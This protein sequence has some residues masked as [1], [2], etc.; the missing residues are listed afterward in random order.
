MGWSDRVENEVSQ[1][2]YRINWLTAFVIRSL[3]GKRVKVSYIADAFIR[4]VGGYKDAYCRIMASHVKATVKKVHGD[5][6]KVLV[7]F[8]YDGETLNAWVNLEE[9]TPIEEEGK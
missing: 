8:E 6:G 3:V 1:L 5:E 9:I 4:R 2:R 7:E